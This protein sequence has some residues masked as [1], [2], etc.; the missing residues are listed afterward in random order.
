[1]LKI[2]NWN[3]ERV[4]PNLTR[5]KRIE[6]VMSTIITDIWI[7]TETHKDIT[8]MPFYSLVCEEADKGRSSGERWSALLSRYPIESLNNFVSDKQRC[9]AGKIEHPQ[10][11]SIIIYALVLPWIGSKW[12]GIPSQGGAAFAAALAMYQSD[13]KQLKKIY[14]KALH[15]VGGDF[16]QSLSDWHYYGSIRNRTKLEQA[17]EECGLQ[18]VTSG[19]N[20][21]IA[22]DSPPHACIDHICI[23]KSKTI[24]IIST[25]RWSN[26]DKPDKKLS[27]HFGVLVELSI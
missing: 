15:V 19:K 13:W 14:P 6:A 24:K 8:P 27:D 11:G 1:M 10:F 18:A 12:Q 16:N 20:D 25:E 26:T 22:R 23:S 21:P 4:V 9:V 2:A 3:L 7:L 17:L 5:A